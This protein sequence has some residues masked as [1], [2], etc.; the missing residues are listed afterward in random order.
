MDEKAP[1]RTLINLHSGAKS[2][3]IGTI[4]PTSIIKHPRYIIT[5]ARSEKIKV[6]IGAKIENPPKVNA[7]TAIV[8]L[9]ANIEAVIESLV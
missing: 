3:P 7:D 4:K 8:E 6:A 5:S 1:A 2:H 9:I